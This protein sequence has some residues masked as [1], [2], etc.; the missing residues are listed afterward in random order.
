MIPLLCITFVSLARIYFTDFSSDIILLVFLYL[1]P[2]PTFVKVA[3]C[4]HPIMQ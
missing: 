2:T 4:V 1:K 3:F